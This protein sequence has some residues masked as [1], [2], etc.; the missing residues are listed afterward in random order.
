MLK[1]EDET[2]SLAY[3]K[4]LEALSPAVTMIIGNAQFYYKSQDATRQERAEMESYPDQH[5]EDSD[6]EIMEEGLEEMESNVDNEWSEVGLERFLEE[7]KNRTHEQLHGE[8]AVQCAKTTCVFGS[9]GSWL[10]ETHP[11][12]ITYSD[13][14][15]RKEN[16]LWK[17][18]M[19]P[20]LA[21][22]LM[23]D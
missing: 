15:K 16:S 6:E 8:H 14:K 3:N 1:G 12:T 5:A 18:A 20:E 13:I 2:W 11:Q 10:T 19:M 23:N 4:F 22:D 9:T 17:K 7:E 21:E